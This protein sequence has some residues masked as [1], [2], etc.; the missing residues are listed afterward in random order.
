[1]AAAVS[2]DIL[3]K[4]E[5]GGVCLYYQR[6]CVVAEGVIKGITDSVKS[7]MPDARVDGYLIT[8]MISNGIDCLAESNRTLYSAR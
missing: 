5:I 8:P 6:C 4:T 3:H 1:M 2:P 7:A